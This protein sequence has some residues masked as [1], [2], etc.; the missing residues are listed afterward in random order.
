MFIYKNR[1]LQINLH[2]KLSTRT[3]LTVIKLSFWVA[4]INYRFKNYCTCV[5]CINS[6]WI[7]VFPHI[8]VHWYH[9]LF[10]TI[11]I[12]ISGPT[13]Q[14]PIILMIIIIIIFRYRRSWILCQSPVT[15]A[16]GAHK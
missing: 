14:T 6:F 16:F 7:H 10:G 2:R 3:S 1:A 5:K 4:Q 9:L 13:I 15:Y 11:S 8:A 12:L